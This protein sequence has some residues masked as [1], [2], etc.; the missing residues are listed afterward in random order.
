MDANSAV[1]AAA[2]GDKWKIP[3]GFGAPPTNDSCAGSG[4]GPGKSRH[5][6]ANAEHPGDRWWQAH[7]RLNST[8]VEVF[9]LAA[10]FA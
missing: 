6:M 4:I 3:E 1:A 7:V 9:K 5:G 2:A 8:A 10:K